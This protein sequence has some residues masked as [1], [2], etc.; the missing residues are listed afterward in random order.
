MAN[1]SGAGD[2]Q[3]TPDCGALHTCILALHGV[4][5]GYEGRDCSTLAF[6]KLT[7]I[8]VDTGVNT[9]ALSPCNVM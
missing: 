5:Y 6:S 3:G 8:V 1:Q 7:D 4:D 2:V 9:C